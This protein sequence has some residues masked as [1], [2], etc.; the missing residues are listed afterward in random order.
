MY[1]KESKKEKKRKI[2]VSPMNPD[3]H[4]PSEKVFDRPIISPQNPDIYSPDEKV[5]DAPLISPQNPDIY[6]PFI[7]DK[8]LKGT[9][10]SD[11]ITL[12]KKVKPIKLSPLNPYKPE[13]DD[14][15]D[16][17]KDSPFEK[18]N[19]SIDNDFASINSKPSLN[20]LMIEITSYCD[21]KC[22][23]CY[24]NSNNNK[25]RSLEL[26]EISKLIKDFKKGEGKSVTLTG[27][28]PKLHPEFWGIM[29]L[30]NQNNIE[31][32]IFTNGFH[33]D[34]RDIQRIK[35]LNLK[36]LQVSVDGIKETHNNFRGV[37]G[38]YQKAIE[39]LKI[40]KDNSLNTVMMI[41]IHQNNIHEIPELLEIAKK[42]QVNSVN[43]NTY[44]PQGRAKRLPTPNLDDLKLVY[45]N[46]EL[47]VCP[48]SSTTSCGIGFKKIAIL[49]NGDIV[50]CE[51]LNNLVVGNINKDNIFEV[52]RK[53]SIME[54][55]RNSTVENIEQCRSCS[56]KN[57]CKGG[58]KASA[59]LNSQS[60]FAPDERQCS[61]WKK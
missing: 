23:H 40:A 42:L 38:S 27:G 48:S 18:P 1:L 21:F 7:G 37:K 41:T 14:D 29:E 58:C 19:W 34:M 56:A 52:F 30:L 13:Y 36:T 59:W 50:P 2:L 16:Q 61:I 9:Q 35:K 31:S 24:C 3:I 45:Q 6:E 28:E 53:S 57:V 43:L 54:E 60:F 10:L 44:M 8:L 11:F 22:K 47:N 51:V 46:I 4:S 25:Y 39:T 15:G 33:W 49:S 26:R 20:H 32:S 5:F 12:P 55:I 17:D